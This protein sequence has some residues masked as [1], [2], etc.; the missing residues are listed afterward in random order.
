MLSPCIS[1]SQAS[2]RH[3]WSGSGIESESGRGYGGEW[4]MKNGRR[5]C[6]LRWPV[7]MENLKSRVR[8]VG[9]CVWCATDDA[10]CMNCPN[11]TF[12]THISYL[13]WSLYIP[14]LA[15]LFQNH[16]ISIGLWW[17]IWSAMKLKICLNSCQEYKLSSNSAARRCIIIK[18][19]RKEWLT[20]V[21]WTGSSN[22]FWRRKPL[23]PVE[24]RDKSSNTKVVLKSEW[25]NVQSYCGF[26]RWTCRSLCY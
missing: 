21:A 22:L 9:A 11:A 12:Q 10:S 24:Y 18:A 8:K 25:R 13:F 7:F 16:P 5:V 6:M 19:C 2:S 20:K 14:F 1:F 3:I 4:E 15:I 17:T 23:N 26:C